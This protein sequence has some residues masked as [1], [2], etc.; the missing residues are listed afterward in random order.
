MIPL[1]VEEKQSEE[2]KQM[3]QRYRN[4]FGTAEGRVVI[5]NILTRFCNFGLV[6]NDD[7]DR[8]EYNLGLAIAEMSGIMAEIDRIVG[9]KEG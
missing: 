8:I 1:T 2:Y 6:L 5:G 4:V 9:I 7:I 3:R